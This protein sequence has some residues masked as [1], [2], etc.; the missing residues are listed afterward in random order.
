MEM[1]TTCYLTGSVDVTIKKVQRL[2]N[3]F[4]LQIIAHNTILT[5]YTTKDQLLKMQN[6]IVCSLENKE[7]NQDWT[8]NYDI[9]EGVPI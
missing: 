9:D 8:I 3:S 7:T 5:I 6:D 2:S 4:K 1:E